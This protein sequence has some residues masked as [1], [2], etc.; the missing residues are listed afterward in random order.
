MG[1]SKQHIGP[2]DGTFGC[3]EP[4]NALMHVVMEDWPNARLR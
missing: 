3:R 4:L 2:P 1:Q